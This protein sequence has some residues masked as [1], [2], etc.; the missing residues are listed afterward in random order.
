MASDTTRLYRADHVL[1]VG[2][3]TRILAA[4]TVRRQV[5]AALDLGTG[6]GV[7]ALLAARHAE[8]VV[9]VDLNRRALRL[10]R[11]TLR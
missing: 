5:G 7:H 4:L 11:S 8:R 1:G 6:S 2:G 9:G 10:A 3:A